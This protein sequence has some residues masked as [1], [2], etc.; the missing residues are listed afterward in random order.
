[1]TKSNFKS[2]STI[3]FCSLALSAAFARPTTKADYDTASIKVEVFKDQEGLTSEA[4]I[5]DTFKQITVVSVNG[6]IK[7]AYV[8]SS[9]KDNEE[10]FA[11]GWIETPSGYFRFDAVEENFVY[12]NNSGTD[13]LEPWGLYFF[14]LPQIIPAGP[15]RD[16]ALAKDR[17]NKAALHSYPKRNSSGVL[18]IS[19][20]RLSHGCI[21][22]PLD[23]IKAVWEAVDDTRDTNGTDSRWDDSFDAALAIY[24]RAAVYARPA[25]G[26]VLSMPE[27][28]R[29]TAFTSA[30][31]NTIRNLL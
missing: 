23:H 15:Q 30:E 4:A 17:R 31:A 20:S 26:Q 21:R 1:M 12:H 13:V 11:D 22:S 8:I 14:D 3:A 19:G 28:K 2:V 10:G 24:G 18:Q 5:M 29:P 25:P 16:A 7:D 9:G 6:V 27:L